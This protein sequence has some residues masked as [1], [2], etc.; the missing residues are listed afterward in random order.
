MRSFE[1]RYYIAGIG[2]FSFSNVR[3]IV[4]VLMATCSILQ[5]PGCYLGSRPVSYRSPEPVGVADAVYPRE[6]I[7][8]GLK[9]F[10]S[11]CTPRTYIGA[12]PTRDSVAFS[13]DG[14]DFCFDSP[15]AGQTYNRQQLCASSFSVNL[16]SHPLTFRVYVSGDG[17]VLDQPKA[18]LEANGKS[19]TA[20]AQVRSA[21]FMV[22]AKQAPPGAKPLKS[23]G[24]S[25]LL[26]EVPRWELAF[27]FDQSCDPDTSYR[28]TLS[29]ITANGRRLKVPPVDFTRYREWLP[30]VID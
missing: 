24:V 8:A 28:L 3:S 19:S 22:R 6:A 4:P 11:I 25:I 27:S 21:P 12:T 13:A 1:A 14:A 10:H 20:A 23:P 15:I 26:Y 17:V 16:N 7:A 5:L 30:V 2:R 29:G 18:K 9:D